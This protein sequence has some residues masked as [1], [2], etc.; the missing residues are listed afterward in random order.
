MKKLF[1]LMAAFSLLILASCQQSE[2]VDLQDGLT[3]EQDNPSGFKLL[4]DPR[5]PAEFMSSEEITMIQNA[6]NEMEGKTLKNQVVKIPETR[7]AGILVGDRWFLQDNDI[8]IANIN[9][10]YLYI[11]IVMIYYEV[12]NTFEDAINYRLGK[13][14]QYTEGWYTDR[15]QGLKEAYKSGDNMLLFERNVRFEVELENHPQY[16][17]AIVSFP[18]PIHMQWDRRNGGNS[19]EIVMNTQ[20]IKVTY[21]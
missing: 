21:Q 10:E 9:G 19:C 7:G 14:M 1:V 13:N 11:N 5:E 20:R 12:D 6:F 4:S 15:Y 18:D 17:K 16:T 3:N 2:C 8:P